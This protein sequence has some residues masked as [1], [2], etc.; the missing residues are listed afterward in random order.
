MANAPGSLFLHQANAICTFSYTWQKLPHRSSHTKQMSPAHLRTHGKDPWAF[1]FGYFFHTQGANASG[2]F[3]VSE[4]RMDNFRVDASDQRPLQGQTFKE[5]TNKSPCGR[6][7]GIAVENV[8]NEVICAIGTVG[9]YVYVKTKHRL[10]RIIEFE[11][12]SQ[13]E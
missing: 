10:F 6:F 8:P 11:V 2:I 9:R 3:V 13:S 12:Y 4:H 5:L 1:Y 7:Q